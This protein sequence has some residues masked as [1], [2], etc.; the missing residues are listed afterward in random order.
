MPLSLYNRTETIDRVFGDFSSTNSN[1][2]KYY[3]EKD[4]LIRNNAKLELGMF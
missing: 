2:M 3:L 4:G 1:T